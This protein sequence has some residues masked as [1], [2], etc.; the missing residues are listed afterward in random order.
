MNPRLSED[1][2]LG[3]THEQD[4]GEPQH[5]QRR[6]SINAHEFE[7]LSYLGA[8]RVVAEIGTGLGVSTEALATRAKKVYTYDPDPWV[9]DEIVPG[10][11]QEC[12][13]VVAIKGTF[14]HVPEKADLVFVDGDH[15]TDAVRNDIKTIRWNGIDVAIFHDVDEESV[16][17]ALEIEGIRWYRL[18]ERLGFGIIR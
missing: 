8:D 6:R 2:V 11:L 9:A 3:R 5:G 18:S 16:R 12:P 4:P 13:N 1:D 14:A 7:I 15:A 10:L 17:K